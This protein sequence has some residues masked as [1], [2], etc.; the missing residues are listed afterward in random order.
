[1]G[2]KLRVSLAYDINADTA[3]HP[4]QHHRQAIPQGHDAPTPT[5]GQDWLDDHRDK[6][7]DNPGD[8]M[9]NQEQ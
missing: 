5:V 4:Q 1:T 7:D 3:T 6:A 9:K 2:V 8:I